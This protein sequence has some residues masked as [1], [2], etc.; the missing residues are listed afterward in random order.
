MDVFGYREKRW[1]ALIN[2]LKWSPCV[3]QF[4]RSNGQ[5]F[6]ARTTSNSEMP[7]SIG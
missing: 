1:K 4:T 3:M 2:R 6:P 5:F 7:S